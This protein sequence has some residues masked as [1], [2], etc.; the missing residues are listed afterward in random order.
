MLSDSGFGIKRGESGISGKHFW[1]ITE[2]YYRD[3]DTASIETGYLSGNTVSL[4][5]YGPGVWDE[6]R[7]PSPLERTVETVV[8]DGRVLQKEKHGLG[9]VFIRVNH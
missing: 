1:G 5:D 8:A 7:V 3:G 9:T 6:T 2:T 4:R